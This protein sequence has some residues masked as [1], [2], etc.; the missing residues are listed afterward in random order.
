MEMNATKRE[1]RHH[2][3][4]LRHAGAIR[5]D[6]QI[7]ELRLRADSFTVDLHTVPGPYKG[8]SH[9]NGRNQ[10]LLGTGYGTC[11]IEMQVTNL[12]ALAFFTFVPEKDGKP[13]RVIV[14]FSPG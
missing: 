12:A 6:W 7:G 2:R 9:E 8:G 14:D 11:S 1:D 4:D 13:R 10:A 3:A 5:T